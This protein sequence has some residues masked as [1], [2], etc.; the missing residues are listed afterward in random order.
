[1]L[2]FPEG[3]EG[4]NKFIFRAIL[5]NGFKKRLLLDY[6]I[7][8]MKHTTIL[9]NDGNSLSVSTKTHRGIILVSRMWL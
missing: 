9:L 4:C 8:Q 1:V 2:S 6:L 7:L 5:G 3:S